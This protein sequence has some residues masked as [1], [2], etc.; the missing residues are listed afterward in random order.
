[1]IKY[2]IIYKIICSKTYREYEMG[3]YKKKLGLEIWLEMSGTFLISEKWIW[4]ILAF[5]C[6]WFESRCNR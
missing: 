6:G 3:F 2:N 4:I 5:F 1:M